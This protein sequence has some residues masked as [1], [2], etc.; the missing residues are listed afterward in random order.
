[1]S[2]MFGGDGDDPISQ[3]LKLGE[4]AVRRFEQGSPP[5][6]KPGVTVANDDKPKL[7]VESFDNHIYFYANVDSDRCLAMMREIREIDSKLR[8]ERETRDI[9]NKVELTPIW[10]HI[11]S[12][13]GE[14]FA[15]LAVADQLARIRT[16]IYSIVEGVCASAATLISMACTKRF[17]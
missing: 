9:P 13:G 14:L 15:G 4:R 16:P 6:T 10:L 5:E 1:M 7:T 11:H 12:G 3:L 2:K 17:N 8:R